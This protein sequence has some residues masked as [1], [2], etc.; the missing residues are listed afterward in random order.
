MN[1]NGNTFKAV[2]K[3]VNRLEGKEK[4]CGTSKYI[5]DLEFE[6]MVYV[7]IATANVA[8]GILKTIDIEEAKKAKG[9]IDVLTYQDVPGK[10]EMG[11]VVPD[12]PALLKP[13]D[14]IAYVGDYVALIAAE[15]PEEARRA[16][17]KVTIEYVPFTPVS[18]P[19]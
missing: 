11:D 9:V 6:G 10:N 3:K 15:T 4:V 19:N 18:H 5:K 12:Y 16:A 13:G 2:G 17:Q 14:K 1:K 8:H 7:G